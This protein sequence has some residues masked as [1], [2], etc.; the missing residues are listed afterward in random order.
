MNRFIKGY[1]RISRYSTIVLAVATFATGAY[2]WTTRT[3]IYYESYCKEPTEL[4]FE[5][6]YE[7]SNE[8]DTAVF[9]YLSEPE[10]SCV[11]AGCRRVIE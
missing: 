9:N 1:K 2:V 4:V 11:K 5:Q 10:N 6:R 7:N 8:C 3:K